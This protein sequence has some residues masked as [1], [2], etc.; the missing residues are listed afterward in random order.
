MLGIMKL[1][2]VLLTLIGMLIVAIVVFLTMY[3]IINYTNN[4]ITRVERRSRLKHYQYPD[5]LLTMVM[6]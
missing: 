6:L 4:S 1:P 5:M 3:G 2:L